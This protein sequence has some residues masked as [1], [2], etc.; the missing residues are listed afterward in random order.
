MAL[1]DVFDVPPESWSMNA[2]GEAVVNAGERRLLAAIVIQALRD[3]H[4]PQYETVTRDWF[5]S[6]LFG[7][8]CTLLD[9]DPAKVQALV[10]SGGTMPG[11]RLRE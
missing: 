7:L 11:Y 9:I 6:D 4:D 8:L 5:R 2:P 1:S 3:L 10:E